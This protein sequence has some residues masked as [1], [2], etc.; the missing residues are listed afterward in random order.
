MLELG[1]GE[2]G[3]CVALSPL[4][5]PV[6]PPVVSSVFR[7]AMGQTAK[8]TGLSLSNHLSCPLFSVSCAATTPTAVGVTA[9]KLTTNTT[10][11]LSTPSGNRSR[12][13]VSVVT[14]PVLSAVTP[15]NGHPGVAKYAV[16]SQPTVS[17][18]PPSS[19]R[20]TGYTVP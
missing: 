20:L 11:R 1:L 6:E 19:S 15:W 17:A 12:V 16:G 2:F 3:L 13:R 18:G 8:D 10:Q 4:H 5:D 9:P 7:V 14:T